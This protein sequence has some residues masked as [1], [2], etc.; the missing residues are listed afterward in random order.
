MLNRFFKA[1]HKASVGSDFQ[2]YFNSINLKNSPYSPTADEAK[3]DYKSVVRS[4]F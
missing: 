3:K 1:V 2:H 4:R